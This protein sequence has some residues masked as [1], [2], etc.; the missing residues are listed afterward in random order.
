MTTENECS[1]CKTRNPV[2]ASFCSS[3]GMSFQVTSGC[4]Q[5]G[6]E[7]KYLAKF[8]TS[9]G[10]GMGE[11]ELTSLGF[12]IVSDGHWQRDHGEFVRK[13]L[14]KDMEQVFG[15]RSDLHVPQGS[16]AV[17]LAEGVVKEVL[18]PGRQ[19]TVS[20]WDGVR[21]FFS[22]LVG[23]GGVDANSAFYLI[24]LRPVPVPV[25]I[26]AVVGDDTSTRVNVQVLV[27][28]KLKKDDHD[29]L[30]RFLNNTV[31][32]SESYSAKELHQLVKPNVERASKAAMARLTHGDF[33]RAEIEIKNQLSFITKDNG[34][35]L[36]ISVA[37]VNSVTS[38]D[39]HLGTVQ[40][41]NIRNCVHT[42]CGIEIPATLK[43]CTGCGKP[44][45]ALRSPDRNCKKC[46]V[47]VAG[48]LKF[49][50]G[51]GAPYS[52]I[53]SEESALFTSDGQQ[54][55][56]D[57]VLRCQGDGRPDDAAKETIRAALS[58][59][60]R[61]FL[62][63]V[64]F[65]EISTEA[66]FNKLETDIASEAQGALQ[67]LGLRVVE[68]NVLDVKSKNGEWMLGARA[69]MVRARDEILLGREWLEVESENI[70]L[71]E[72]TFG[73][74]LK[75]QGIERDY[76][77]KQRSAELDDDHRTL[78]LE[79]DH[80]LRTHQTETDHAYATEGVD[81]DDRT[82]RQDML[83]SNAN[84]DVSDAN[85][86]AERDI[87]LDKAGRNLDRHIADEEHSDTLSAENR[88]HEAA[89]LTSANQREAE[90]MGADHEMLMESRVAEHDSNL[91][92]QAMKL[93][94][95][96]TRL[97]VDDDSYA[98]RAQRDIE[99]DD[100]RRFQEL[101]EQA[102]DKAMDRELTADERR[103]KIQS[104]KLAA[105][106]AAES[107]MAAQEQSHAQSMRQML[108]GNAANLSA[109]QLLALQA[110]ELGKSE[111]GAAA[112]EAIS[113]RQQAADAERRQM[114]DREMLLK[115]REEDRQHA[116]L[117]ADRLAQV[118]ADGSKQAQD[119]L[120]QAA[121][122]AQSMSEQAMQSMSNVASTA[123]ERPDV[124]NIVTNLGSE[125]GGKGSGK[126]NNDGADVHGDAESRNLQDATRKNLAQTSGA[127]E[128]KTFQAP[129]CASC[130][131]PLA[132]PYTFCGD[133]GTKQ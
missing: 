116:N 75:Q 95:E 8:C 47:E 28:A 72:L 74:A 89:K 92:R 77:F 108:A 32:D 16:I 40:S 104:D 63:R 19:T 49:C 12:G 71:Q 58:A 33:S 11:V 39:I 94:S 90:V 86:N 78:N 14:P 38:V 29:M 93:G 80:E 7:N 56:V 20:W 129:A 127:V 15:A 26:Q 25:M 124:N 96:Q 21:G 81:L 118:M 125:S 62:R 131:V 27:E 107:S 61:K 126:N 36:D 22:S 1:G 65:D 85:R 130:T 23:G 114:E 50:T 24:D 102:A 34:I 51:C 41:P 31:G 88:R 54:V 84:F 57:M 123:S 3:C 45:P 35:I 106:A 13:V 132:P 73:L 30:A 122:Q 55:E 66:G 111:H 79:L 52:E 110:T 121:N 103:A 60:T 117:N 98:E 119:A 37:P 101:D 115:M 120:K 44:Q 9:C 97:K 42:E 6:S 10:F 48:N 43:F 4:P 109:E 100:K 133:C 2:S 18:P 70:D 69:D 59:A 46:G 76:V 82:R 64:T 112:F 67:T 17:V 105:L 113:G 87:G 53:T 83:D 128:A 5:C 91:A 99:Y 68:V